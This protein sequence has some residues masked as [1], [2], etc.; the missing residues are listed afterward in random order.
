MRIISSRTLP[1]L[2]RK[3]RLKL[4]PPENLIYFTLLYFTLLYFTLLYFTS[5]L[6]LL[7][8]GVHHVCSRKEALCRARKPCNPPG[9]YLM[10]WE[11]SEPFES[12]GGWQSDKNN[13]SILID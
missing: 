5:L 10:C 11:K 4:L 3:G 1:Y 2:K 9:S 12:S 7:S 6:A 13:F 8:P